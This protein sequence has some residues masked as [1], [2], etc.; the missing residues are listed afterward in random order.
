[1]SEHVP[2]RDRKALLEQVGNEERAQVEDLEGPERVE[3]V[4]GPDDQELAHLHAPGE[5]RERPEGEREPRFRHRRLDRVRMLR[6]L[7]P[8]RTADATRRIQRE[9]VRH[10]DVRQADTSL[11]PGTG[12][13]VLQDAI[14]QRA[15]EDE[16]YQRADHEHNLQL[17]GDGALLQPCE[18]DG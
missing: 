12:P 8:D 9:E 6:Q 14:D 3:A 15:H 17:G 10:I 2:P 5:P 13:F 1:M 7:E 16:R 18:T 4:P 11:Q